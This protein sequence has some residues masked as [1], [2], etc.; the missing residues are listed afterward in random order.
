MEIILDKGR[1]IEYYSP[2]DMKTQTTSI[3]AYNY[4]YYTKGEI[5]L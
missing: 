2:T 3:Q 5:C 4:Y 1:G